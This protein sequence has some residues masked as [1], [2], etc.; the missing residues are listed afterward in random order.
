[1]V[2]QDT[3]RRTLSRSS[4]RN[5]QISSLKDLTLLDRTK[6]E[7]RAGS[8]SGSLPVFHPGGEVGWKGFPD[9]V[10]VLAAAIFQNTH[11]VKPAAH[12]L[13][14]F[15][16]KTSGSMPV[17][18]DDVTQRCAYE[19]A[20]NALKYQELLEDIM[21]DSCFYLSQPMPDDLMSLVAVMLY[22]FQDRKF[23]PRERP[24]NQREEPKPEVREVEKCLLKFK[25]KLA[26]SL[27]RCRIKHDLLTIDCILPD[28]V[29]KRQE[30]ANSQPLYAW[31]NTLKTSLS[32]VLDVLMREGFAQVKSSRQLDGQTFCQDPHC[33]DLLAFP[34]QQKAELYRTKLLGQYKLIAQDKSCCVGP[35]LAGGLLVAEGD[36]L[37]AGVP[38]VLTVAHVAAI[39]ALGPRG[40]GL[41]SSSSS[42]SSSVS[43]SGPCRVYVCGGDLQPGQREELQESLVNMGCKNVKVLPE[44]FQALDVNDLRVQRTQLILLTP[45]CSVSAV[46]NPV[47]YLLQENGDTELLQD[48]SQGSIAQAKIDAL[49]AQQSK[50]LKHALNFP[51][52]Q[53]VVYC[54]CSVYP[55]ENEELVSRVLAAGQ[56]DQDRPPFRPNTAALPQQMCMGEV[57]EG[58]ERGSRF[59]KLEPSEDSNGCF[60]AVLTREVEPEATETAQ[61][62]LARAAAKGLLDG[63]QTDPPPKKERPRRRPAFWHPAVGNYGS[64]SA[65]ASGGKIKLPSQQRQP[66]S[67][68][69]NR[70]SSGPMVSSSSRKPMGRTTSTTAYS[71]TSSKISSNISSN[72]S[73]NISSKISSNTSSNI[74]SITSSNTSSITSSNTS[75]KISFNT[76]STTNTSTFTIHPN[77]L[78]A[79]PSPPAP[80]M[81]TVPP[82]GRQ[83][84]LRPMALLLPPAIFPGC[85]SPPAPV[86]STS[87]PSCRAR[88]VRSNPALS[89]LQWKSS[90]PSIPASR[91]SGSIQG[92]YIHPRPWL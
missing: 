72:T 26:A 75:S 86:P 80:P 90:H 79:L 15:G 53:S 48:L 54:T 34:P 60:I 20:F 13:I 74:S 45:Q 1:M 11:V 18:K 52:V 29:R 70:G 84:V 40:P 87:S 7:S 14:S 51:R 32:K 55:E 28:S 82:K 49:V 9:R 68:Q 46:C 23:L 61:E 50:D 85:P 71:N 89:L 22:D 27:A 92:M 59:F 12:R 19:L 35:W 91:S 36:I 78:L 16:K 4:K 64:K 2:K 33:Q 63:I 24:A 3:P 30:K 38:S 47:G 62:V 65:L 83:E 6:S 25:T 21:I 8:A 42:S 17:A 44:A 43:S 73:S 66:K 81:A 41:S 31:V 67:V 57:E 77:R 56:E 37:M 5:S 10:Y 69:P 88:R 39:V 76:S 58:Q